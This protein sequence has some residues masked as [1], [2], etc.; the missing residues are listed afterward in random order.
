[1]QTYTKNSHHCTKCLS[2]ILLPTNT[3]T[4]NRDGD[5]KFSLDFTTTFFFFFYYILRP[6][7]TVKVSV[8][9]GVKHLLRL[10]I[11]FSLVCMVDRFIRRIYYEYKWWWIDKIFFPRFLIFRYNHKFFEPICALYLMWWY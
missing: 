6:T 1:M 8:C 9:Y 7:R 3:T 10:F 11:R 4:P 2:H 5:E